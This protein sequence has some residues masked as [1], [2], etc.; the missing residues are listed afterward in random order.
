MRGL[1]YLTQQNYVNHL[2]IVG[3]IKQQR[4]GPPGTGRR[5]GQAEIGGIDDDFFITVGSENG[6]QT[7]HLQY[8]RREATFK[9]DSFLI[10][11]GQFF[12]TED[13]AEQR[14]LEEELADIIGQTE[15]RS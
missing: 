7:Q 11:R 5:D 2:D 10:N 12:S 9:D 15:K 3:R 14:L 13:I 1:Y 8:N 4:K 6:E